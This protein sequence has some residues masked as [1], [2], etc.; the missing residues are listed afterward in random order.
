M[1]RALRKA[2]PAL[3]H[4]YGLKPWEVVGGTEACLTFGEIAEYQRQHAAYVK[5]QSKK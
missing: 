5:A 1:R 2:L 4:F 3:T